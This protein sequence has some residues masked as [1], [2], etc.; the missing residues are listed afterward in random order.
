MQL[1]ENCVGVF[2]K[3]ESDGFAMAWKPAPIKSVWRIYERYS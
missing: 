1:V 2:E 3:P